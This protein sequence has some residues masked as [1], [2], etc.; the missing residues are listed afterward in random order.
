MEL[1]LGTNRPMAQ[2]DLQEA[3]DTPSAR[4]ISFSFAVACLLSAVGRHGESA[5]PRSFARSRYPC[6][7]AR[8]PVQ[9]RVRD[10]ATTGYSL[11]LWIV[12]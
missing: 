11:F 6:S 1:R 7:S 10:A 8:I 2:T 3:L 12:V 5:F 9:A 4:F